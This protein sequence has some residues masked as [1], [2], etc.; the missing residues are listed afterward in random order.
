MAFPEHWTW[1]E[2]M[3]A[4]RTRDLVNNRLAVPEWEP[5][6]DEYPH[7]LMLTNNIGT[8]PMD[9]RT[10]QRMLRRPAPW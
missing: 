10:E 6:E 1:A 2:R 7:E 5:D 4:I 8:R 9:K 3:H